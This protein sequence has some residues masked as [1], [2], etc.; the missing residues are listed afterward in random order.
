MSSILKKF[1][2]PLNIILALFAPAIVA[3]EIEAIEAVKGVGIHEVIKG[4]N[5]YYK[6]TD[7]ENDQIRFKV[8]M[9]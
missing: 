2:V 6:I 7:P 3:E 9:I 8:R 4:V 1:I 5:Y